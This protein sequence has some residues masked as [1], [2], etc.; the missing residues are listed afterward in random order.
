MPFT[1]RAFLQGMA[2]AA[3][4]VVQVLEADRRMKLGERQVATDEASQKLASK[5]YETVELPESQARIGLAEFQLTSMK[6]MADI[7][8]DLKKYQRD[9]EAI[10]YSDR[11]K[12]VNSQARQTETAASVAEQTAPD[13]VR[14]SAANANMA[15]TQA[16]L[17]RFDAEL[18]TKYA[19]KGI[20]QGIQRTQAEINSLMA[21]TANSV[22]QS[23]LTQADFQIKLLGMA[24][25]GLTDFAMFDGTAFKD[26]ADMQKFLVSADN[27]SPEFRRYATGVGEYYQKM[28]TS[29]DMFNMEAIS[30]LDP[31]T[32]PKDAKQYG[33]ILE[34][35]TRDKLYRFSRTMDATG[36]FG[37]TDRF[38]LS[39]PEYKAQLEAEAAKQKHAAGGGGF[40]V[41]GGISGA[42]NATQPI[43][44]FGSKVGTDLM[45]GTTGMASK[46]YESNPLNPR[47]GKE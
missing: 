36:D 41:A 1:F 40:D 18:R 9:F 25:N 13:V 26:Y 24:A 5:R 20:L 11:V 21:S 28:E 27:I 3:P 39:N 23:K 34:T 4:Q 42:Y 32:K 44:D 22:I 30:R 6:R 33:L 10:T 43:R 7:E 12:I 45:I 8:Y 29:M 37:L 47:R 19:E 14:T 16:A 2:E 38:L 46:L 35:S 15:E 31:K 17:A